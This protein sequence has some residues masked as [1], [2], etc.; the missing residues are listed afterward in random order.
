L[1]GCPGV[2]CLAVAAGRQSDIVHGL[3]RGTLAVVGR[4]LWAGSPIAA[5]VGDQDCGGLRMQI[6][7]LRIRWLSQD[8]ISHNSVVLTI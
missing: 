5:L 3:S 1:V 7:G 6:E 8:Q 4:S 2:V